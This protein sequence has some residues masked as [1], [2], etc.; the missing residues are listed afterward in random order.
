MNA[1]AWVVTGAFLGLASIRRYNFI[2]FVLFYISSLLGI[3][4]QL[5]ASGNLVI[6]GA[7]FLASA[8]A[9]WFSNEL[10]SKI[11][12]GILTAKR[13]ESTILRHN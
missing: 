2:L 10:T 6:E 3:M 4:H 11:R 7:T 12:A 5:A 1:T 9:F 8:V 13:H